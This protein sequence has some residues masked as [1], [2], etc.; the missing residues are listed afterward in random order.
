[1]DIIVFF[2]SFVRF[3]IA[4]LTS[5]LIFS[6]SLLFLSHYRQ[7]L[8]VKTTCKILIL[9]DSHPA[10]ALIDKNGVLNLA[11]S[12]EAWFYQ[13]KKGEFLISQNQNISKV[14]LEINP[15]QFSSSI[16]K[17]IWDQEFSARAIKSYYALLPIDYHLRILF[18]DPRNF[19]KMSLFAQKRMLSIVSGEYDKDFYRKMEWGGYEYSEI[20]FDKQFNMNA[21]SIDRVYL[22]TLN[23]SKANLQA[24]FDFV[25][26]CKSK[27]VELILLRC[28]IHKLNDE[29]FDKEISSFLKYRLYGLTYF[30]FSSFEMPDSCYRDLEHLNSYGASIFSN[31]FYTSVLQDG[32]SK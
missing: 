29:R 20:R 16:S 11:K 27:N 22:D 17:W 3:S 13:V 8:N 15:R 19:L 28:P 21:N 1:M 14:I 18:D 2:W 6:G 23:Y 4:L 30:D 26:L 5:F 25:E 12:G 10:C 31:F 32:L 7:S 24:L 9:G